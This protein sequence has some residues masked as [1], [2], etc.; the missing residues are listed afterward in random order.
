MADTFWTFGSGTGGTGS[1]Q[2]DRSVFDRAIDVLRADVTAAAAMATNDAQVRLLYQRQISEAASALERAARSGQLSWAQAADEAILLRNTTLE[3]LRGRTSPV[4]RAMAEQMKKYGLN[5]QTLL[6]RYTELLFGAGA[7]FDRLSAAEQHRVYAEVVRASG[8]SNP[9][10]NAMMQRASRFGRGLIVLSIGVS[11]YN[12]AVADDPGAQALQEGA[13]MGGG[14]AGGIA[15][16][17]AAGLVCGPGA[18]VCV[19]IG[20]FVGGALAAFGVSLFF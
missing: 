9:Q 16:G 15:G 7:R 12:I 6:A 10:V 3:A 18:P 1:G 11:V 8:R 13:V 14:I 20:A 4:G 5:R 19:G 2:D 17:A